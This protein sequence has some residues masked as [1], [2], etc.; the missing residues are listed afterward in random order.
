MH[1]PFGSATM[2]QSIA[3][4]SAWAEQPK[5]DDKKLINKK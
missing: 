3:G 2:P 4:T 1:T 5:D